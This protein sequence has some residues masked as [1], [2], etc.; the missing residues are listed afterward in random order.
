M[1]ISR[2]IGMTMC[3]ALVVALSSAAQAEIKSEWVEY[4]HGDVKL[5]GYLAY[6]DSIRGRRPAVLVIHARDGMT[7]NARN[8]VE[9]FAK[10]GYVAFA[11]D[12]FGYGQGVLPKDVPEMQAQTA[13]YNKDRPLMRSR[14]QAGYDA[15]L[16]NPMVDATK[17]ALSGYCFGGTVGVEFGSTGVPLAAN[18]A[19]HGSFNN[20]QPGWA[21]TIKG[22]YLILHGA[23]DA[24][25]PLTTVAGIIDE[26]RAAKVPFQYEVYSG[27]TH[28]FT[29]P[30]SEP[31]KRANIQS[32]ASAARFLKETFSGRVAVAADPGEEAPPSN[33]P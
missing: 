28:G 21:K 33:R 31:D 7:Q 14:A 18:I 22:R 10:L 2:K 17:V 13:I 30:K 16:K 15:L 1:T 32:R 6:D 4:V 23:E 19:F 24:G 11:A 29:V 25:F 3:A 8:N 20:H 5:K 12:M 26:L 9:S 27:A